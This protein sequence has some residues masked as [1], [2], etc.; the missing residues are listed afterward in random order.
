MA[1]PQWEVGTK[2]LDGGGGPPQ[3]P[4]SVTL[5]STTDLVSP[6]SGEWYGRSALKTVDGI[7]VWCYRE[8]TG[9]SSDDGCIHIRFSDDEGATW[10]DPDKDLEG[11]AVTGF[12]AFPPGSTYPA[13]GLEPGEPWLYVAPNG[14]LLLHTWLVHYGMTHL[15]SWQLRSTDGGLTW[16]E[17]EQINFVGL[18]ASIQ[19]NIFSTDDD[20]TYNG[21]I[22]AA[23]RIYTDTTEATAKNIFIKSEDNGTTW[24]YVSDIC[25]FTDNCQEVGLVYVGNNTIRAVLRRN[26]N[27]GIRLTKSTNM[28]QSW[29]QLS[30]ENAIMTPSGRHRIYTL[31]QLRGEANWWTDKNLLMCGFKFET[32]GQSMGRINCVWTSG[33]SGYSWSAPTLL[34]ISYE[35]A[36]YGD[37]YYNANTG[38][39]YY[40]SYR[41][42]QAEAKITQYEMTVS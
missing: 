16:G 30:N 39:Y 10:S 28:G 35:D 17:W 4:P 19:N 5:V 37:L 25:S 6:S 29:A 23:A 1:I 14:D 3:Q 7:K 38:H 32:P 31:A 18:D 41:G 15:G 40:I 36:G 24:Q 26:A 11:N 34:D 13:F 9:H 42:T 22:Y 33:D 20:F 21:V 2:P 8:G 27:D 12:P